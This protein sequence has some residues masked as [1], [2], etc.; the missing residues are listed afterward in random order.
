MCHVII[1]LSQRISDNNVFAS[2][3][4]WP[5]SRLAYWITNNF[6]NIKC[7]IVLGLV[8]RTRKISHNWP[9]VQL[10]VAYI[11][12][13]FFFPFG[14]FCHVIRGLLAFKKRRK[15]TDRHLEREALKQGNNIIS[16][17][18]VYGMH[19]CIKMC[20]LN[21]CS[22]TKMKKRLWFSMCDC[23]CAVIWYM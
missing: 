23:P 12:F 22:H 10:N 7:C 3:E 8:W 4:I 17:P 20:I 5:F 9:H 11:F 6:W 18:F 14:D 13:T 1:G 16:F 19:T 2:A 21:M 15:T